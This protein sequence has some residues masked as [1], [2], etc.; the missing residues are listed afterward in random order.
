MLQNEIAS[1]EDERETKTQILNK[2]TSLAQV[3]KSIGKSKL[4][5]DNELDKFQNY[6]YNLELFVVNQQE[7]QSYLK[8]ENHTRNVTRCCK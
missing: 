2:S 3:I 7:A 6:T 8:Y 4:F 1:K 5:W